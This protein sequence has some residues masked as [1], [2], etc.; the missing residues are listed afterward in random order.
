MIDALDVNQYGQVAAISMEAP[1]LAMLSRCSDS[2]VM[3]LN[4]RD[5][6]KK[7]QD[8]PHDT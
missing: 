1:R 3:D 5:S 2:V 8:E 4:E 7:H 6:H